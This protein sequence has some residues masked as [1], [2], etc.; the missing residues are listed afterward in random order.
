MN[1]IDCSAIVFIVGRYAFAEGHMTPREALGG[2][3]Q[4]GTD[5]PW[6]HAGGLSLVSSRTYLSTLERGGKSPTIEKLDAIAKR[7]DIHP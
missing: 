7:M 5:S 3:N 4:E 1:T 6:P 2:S